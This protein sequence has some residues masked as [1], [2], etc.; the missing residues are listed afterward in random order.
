VGGHK[1]FL[2]TG[3]YADGRLGEIFIDMHKE[4]AAFR[5]IMNCLA[6]SVSVGLQ[7]GVPL[8]TYVEQFTF[9]RFE[10]QGVVEGHP[11][12]KMATSIIDYIFRVIG[13][14]YLQRYDLCHVKPLPAKTA[15]PSDHAEYRTLPTADSPLDSDPPP[16]DP[17]T[18][19]ARSPTTADHADPNRGR[20]TVGSLNAQL[21]EMM[22]DAPLCDVCGHIT[23]RNGACYRCLNCGNSMGC[24]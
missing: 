14:E 17:R 22:G 21:E 4:G 11:N 5:S 15:D 8:D 18:T 12:I 20:E 23:V 16:S 10:P 7:Y 13:V 24:S 3:E 6:I 2:R 19:L 9:T 1:I